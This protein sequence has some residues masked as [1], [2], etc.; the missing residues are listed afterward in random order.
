MG[1]LLVGLSALL[2]PFAM[3]ASW[4]IEQNAKL[5]FALILFLETG[6]FGTFT[7]LNFFHWFIY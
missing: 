3:L 6:L 1:L 2:V 5:Y 4:K 7:A